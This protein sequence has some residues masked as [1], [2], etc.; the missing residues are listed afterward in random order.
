[1]LSCWEKNG[2]D[3]AFSSIDWKG[4]KRALSHLG[5][6]LARA[7]LQCSHRATNKKWWYFTSAGLFSPF[8]ITVYSCAYNW[9]RFL[10]LAVIILPL[11]SFQI[12]WTPLPVEWFWGGPLSMHELRAPQQSHT[13]FLNLAQSHRQELCHHASLSPTDKQTFNDCS[14]YLYLLHWRLHSMQGEN[15]SAI[16]GVRAKNLLS[17]IWDKHLRKKGQEVDAYLWKSANISAKAWSRMWEQ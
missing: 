5:D 8:S 17:S 1:M 3:L 6:L 7:R 2:K 4:L 15:W 14:W 16:S 12:W 10:G 9:L 11:W 13:W